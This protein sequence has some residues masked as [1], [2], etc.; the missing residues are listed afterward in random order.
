M[1]MTNYQYELIPVDDLK[2]NVKPKE[3]ESAF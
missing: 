2:I 1:F 3:E